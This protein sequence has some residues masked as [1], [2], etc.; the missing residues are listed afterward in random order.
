M[1]A[2]EDMRRLHSVIVIH[3]RRQAFEDAPKET[4]VPCFH[5]FRVSTPLHVATQQDFINP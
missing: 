3:Q 1:R 5:P 2:R 4:G